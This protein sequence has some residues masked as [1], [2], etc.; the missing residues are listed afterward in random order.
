[1]ELNIDFKNVPQRYL[2]NTKNKSCLRFSGQIT[3]AIELKF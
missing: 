2:C 1:M 3:K